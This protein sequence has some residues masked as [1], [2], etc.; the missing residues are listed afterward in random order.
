MHGQRAARA[1]QV[2][3]GAEL[4][5]GVGQVA[6]QVGSQ[7]AVERAVDAGGFAPLEPIVGM[8]MLGLGAALGI[9]TVALV[10]FGA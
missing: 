1:Q 5:V 2:P 3:Q 10:I 9:A 7:D 8:V 6:D 4:A